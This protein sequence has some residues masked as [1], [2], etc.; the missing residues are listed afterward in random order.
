MY[1]LPWT[2][3]P[4][5]PVLPSSPL[6]LCWARWLGSAMWYSSL[7][8]RPTSNVAELLVFPPQ[9]CNTKKEEDIS[10]TMKSDRCYRRVRWGHLGASIGRP[11][12]RV[13]SSSWFIFLDTSHVLEWGL[14]V[15]W[16]HSS[17]PQLAES[18]VKDS[19]RRAWRL[20]MC[21]TRCRPSELQKFICHDH[22][23]E[24]VTTIVESGMFASS[25][26]QFSLAFLCGLFD[27]F[28][29]WFFWKL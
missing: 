1:P 12:N 27:I 26:L 29:T 8:E 11:S 10:Q 22:E 5:L 23:C 15:A 20:I 17:R 13:L 14:G 6:L 24:F 18:L 2:T 3:W 19:G 25:S 16:G 7:T 4:W 9:D 21:L 28:F